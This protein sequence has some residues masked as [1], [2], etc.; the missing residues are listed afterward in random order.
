MAAGANDVRVPIDQNDRLVAAA[1]EA[2]VQ[3]EYL[4][5]GDEGHGFRRPANRI[6]AVEAYVDFLNRFLGEGTTAP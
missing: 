2:R 5:F 6:T 3:V 4:V 1:R